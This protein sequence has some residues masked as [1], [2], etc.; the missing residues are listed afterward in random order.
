MKKICVLHAPK[1]YVLKCPPQGLMSIA[2]YLKGNNINID[3]LDA[4]IHYINPKIIKCNS[5][6]KLLKRKAYSNNFDT[7]KQDFPEKELIEYLHSNNFD[8]VLTDCNFTGT[9]SFSFKTFELIKK[10]LPNAIII[11]GGIHSTIFHKEILEKYPVDIITR[12]EG[13]EVT[14]NV[15]K[16]LLSNNPK[17]DGIEGISYKAN[18]NIIINPGS[19]LVKDLNT[20]YPVYDVYDDFEIDLYREYVKAVLGPFW[21]DQDPTGVVLTSRGCVGRCTFCNGRV[22][23]RGKYRSLSKENIIKQLT[24]LYE[25]YR[26]KK[27]GI[28]DAMFGGDLDTYKAVCDFFR[29][30]DVQWGFE[31]R[32]DVMTSERLDY[33][34]GTHCKYILYGLESVNLNTLKLNRKI[35]KSTD[36]NYMNKAA[37]LFRK[38]SNLKILCV[39]SI[40]YGLPGDDYAVFENTI[41]FILNNVLNNN[42]YISYLFYIPIMYPGTNL[43]YEADE[44]DRCYEW[45]K[46]FVNNENII[47]EG[48]IIYKNPNVDINKLKFYV[49]NSNRIL[50]NTNKGQHYFRKLIGKKDKIKNIFAEGHNGIDSVLNLKWFTLSV[51]YTLIEKC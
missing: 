24:Y 26:P 2:A 34:K 27:F 7:V 5:Y 18:N 29:D 19:G 46:Y 6:E 41:N 13:E 48:K 3:I 42:Y 15:I 45:D 50:S 22:I 12:G 36:D 17:L 25:K 38:T 49:D 11:T 23:D 40:L 31:T 28:Y 44:N 8:I 4:N 39:V 21:G 37:E 47:E 30:R 20:L 9:A 33:V 51:L 43:W 1:P 35:P 10:I 16:A 14:L 32:I